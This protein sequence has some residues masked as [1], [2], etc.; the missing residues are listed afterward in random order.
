MSA[1]RRRRRPGGAGPAWGRGRS[2]R[3]CGTRGR[4]PPPPHLR[5]PQPPS[6]RPGPPPDAPCRP[7]RRK[8]RPGPRGAAEAAST[9]PTHAASLPDAGPGRCGRGRGTALARP[10]R[11][12]RRRAADEAGAA[13]PAARRLT[14]APWP[15][16]PRSGRRAGH[17]RRHRP[18]APGARVRPAREADVVARTGFSA[19]LRRR[20]RL[21][22]PRRGCFWRRGG[23]A[24]RVAETPLPEAARRPRAV[25]PPCAGGAAKCGATARIAAY[26]A[27]VCQPPVRPPLSAEPPPFSTKRRRVRG[28]RRRNA[29]CPLSDCSTKSGAEIRGKSRGPGVAIPG[30]RGRKSAPARRLGLSR[31][32]RR[33]GGGRR[34]PVRCPAGR[35]GAPRSPRR[36]G[37][38]STPPR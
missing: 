18:E 21:L 4:R 38:R 29:R 34:V 23:T 37:R 15:P 27:I 36:R 32:R 6:R 25:S 11:R 1:V 19:G 22:R 33:G 13:P 31:R 5:R 12:G 3:S 35:P 26:R 14:P 17:G 20:H 10:V 30:A 8:G 16:Q 28:K 9:G 24:G 7:P 2:G